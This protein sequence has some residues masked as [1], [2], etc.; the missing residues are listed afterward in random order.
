MGLSMDSRFDIKAFYEDF[1]ARVRRSR[2][3]MSQRELGARV[4]LS[5]GSISNIEAGRQHVPLHL[6]PILAEALGVD[7][8]DLIASVEVAHHVDV[9]GFAPDE[10]HFVA[11]VIARVR[12]VGDDGSS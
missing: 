1:G 5:R 12:A 6:S 10:R 9:T 2:G 11:N 3:S 8:R 7:A 4:G